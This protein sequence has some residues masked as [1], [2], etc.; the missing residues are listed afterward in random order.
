MDS[1]H[2]TERIDGYLDGEF[3]LAASLE[4]ERHLQGC[5][6]CRALLAERRALSDPAAPSDLRHAG[7]ARVNARADAAAA[8]V[9]RDGI[10]AG[11]PRAKAQAAADEAA[12]NVR[13][14]V[15]S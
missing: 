13:A 10:R 8:Q 14:L 4:I 2:V 9:Y 7:S 6:D 15:L 12:A 11:L 1:R 5:P 3:D